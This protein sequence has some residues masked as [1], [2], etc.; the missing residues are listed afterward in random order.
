MG[1]WKLALHKSLKN[2]N[3]AKNL[4]F[5]H[6]KYVIVSTEQGSYQYC[7]CVQIT[8]CSLL[9]KEIRYWQFTWQPY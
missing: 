2:P 7:F 6:V 5:L 4:S 3:V 8:L 9:D 1:L